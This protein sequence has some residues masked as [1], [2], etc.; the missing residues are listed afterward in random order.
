MASVKTAPVLKIGWW[1]ALTMKPGRSPL[2]CYVGQ[3]EA[4]GAEGV[5]ITMI[6]WLIGEAVGFDFFAPWESIA[7]AMIAT[8]AH[9]LKGFGESAGRWQASCK[10]NGICVAHPSP[11]SD[12]AS[13]RRK[14]PTDA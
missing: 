7:S 11:D 6:D 12:T 13:N 1:V 4:V 3:I 5:R 14:E 10:M 8:E 9:D 2:G